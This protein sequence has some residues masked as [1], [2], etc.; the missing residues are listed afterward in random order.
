[1]GDGAFICSLCLSA[2]VLPHSPIYSSSQC[3][4]LHLYLYIM[5]LFCQM[6]SLS[7]GLTKK[8]PDSPASLEV[9]LYSKFA[10][11]VFTAFT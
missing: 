7:L 10:A 3:T 1:M 8:V 11:D 9:H 4:L 2:N 5:S 6:V